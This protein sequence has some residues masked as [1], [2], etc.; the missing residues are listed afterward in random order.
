[1]DVKKRRNMSMSR[2]KVHMSRLSCVQK[3]RTTPPCLFISVWHLNLGYLLETKCMELEW[4]ECEVLRILLYHNWNLAKFPGTLFPASREKCWNKLY[5]II[6]LNLVELSSTYIVSFCKAEQFSK[7][8]A[9][10]PSSLEVDARH[11][12]WLQKGQSPPPPPLLLCRIA[13]SFSQWHLNR[14]VQCH[15]ETH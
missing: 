9:H 13:R 11:F 10:L 2:R 1:M 5:H 4:N 6:A 15:E 14:I 8:W 7:N 12:P 3:F